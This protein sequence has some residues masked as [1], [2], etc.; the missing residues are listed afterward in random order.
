MHHVKNIAIIGAP[1]S[2]KGFYGRPLAAHL[3]LPLVTASSVLRENLTGLDLTSGKMVDCHVVSSVLRRHLALA[4]AEG[5]I[6]DGFPRT[7]SQLKLML[8]TWPTD[9]RANFAIHLDVPDAVCEKIMLGRRQCRKCGRSFSIAD[10]HMLGF[11]LPPQL[12]NKEENN[13]CSCTEED[14]ITREDDVL[15]TIRKR[16]LT[17]HKCQSPVLEHFQ[18]R[19]RLLSLTPYHG[20]ADIPK[21]TD[22][23]ANWLK[24]FK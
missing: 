2:G 13:S 16:L 23:V 8:R 14:W 12:P 17:Y 4:K 7:K 3:N 11:N 9:Y 22:Q 6:M 5:Y 10:V 19:A 20:K 15:D 24:T 21:L 1:G 18:R